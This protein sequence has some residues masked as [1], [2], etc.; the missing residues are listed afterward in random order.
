VNLS[1]VTTVGDLA[2]ILRRS[3]LFLSNDSGPVHIAS[4]VG[5]PSVVIFGRKDAG[6]SPRRWGPT[7]AKDVAL[8]KDVGCAKCLAHECKIG[9][10]C[11]EAVTV[12]EVTAAAEKLLA[13][14]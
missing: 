3:K 14:R 12:E 10:K 7:G 1:G 4:A 2:S 6:L 13:A 5:T 9:F 8:H 11:L